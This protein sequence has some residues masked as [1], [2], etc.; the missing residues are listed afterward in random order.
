[1]LARRDDETLREAGV[2]EA[3]I[4]TAAAAFLREHPIRLVPN[5]SNALTAS[6]VAFLKEGGASGV[7]GN[8]AQVQADNLVV[9]TSEYA[10]MAAS[11]LTQK[12]TAE[13]L[14]VSTSRIR[15]RLDANSLYSID[16]GNG[17]VCPRFQF[18]EHQTL[19]GLDVLL[20]CISR[21]VHPVAVQRF[22]LTNNP[23]LISSEVSSPMSPRDWMLSGHS[24]DPVCGLAAEL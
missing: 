6:E 20:K 22:F 18:A 9:I 15:Q 10:Q 11:S 13:L 7:D 5:A 14:G 16:N 3:D 21:D 1:M 2:K 19:P 24:I 8:D 4:L 17:R 12:E 23:D